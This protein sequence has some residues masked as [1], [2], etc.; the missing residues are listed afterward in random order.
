[1]VRQGS[2]S[3]PIFLYGGVVGTLPKRPIGEIRPVA[4]D[5]IARLRPACE[6][7]EIAGSIRRERPQVGDIEIVAIPK[8]ETRSR[9]AQGTL[10]EPP[11]P[12]PA[13]QVSRLWEA[14]DALGV[15]CTKRGPVY[16]QF[17]WRGVRVDVYTCERGNW[18]WILFHRTGPG[19]LRAKIG[20]M[21]VDRGFAAVDGWIWDARGLSIDRVE[22][23]EEA[24]VF[25]VLGIP[26]LPPDRRDQLRGPEITQV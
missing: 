18:G 11:R 17:T 3:S 26:P 6:R 4:E 14:V 5:L 24:D 19:Y 8:F 25:R 23:P 20:S 9:A 22:T 1:M 15:T 12:T 16:R 10:F 21:L 2:R 13:E 7:I